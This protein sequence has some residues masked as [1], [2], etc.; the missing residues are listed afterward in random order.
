[1]SGINE[2]LYQSLLGDSEYQRGGEARFTNL[3]S[4]VYDPSGSPD[5]LSP[6][7]HL[8]LGFINRS[9]FQKIEGE[10][11]L[12]QHG[13]L[14][15]AQWEGRKAWAAGYLDLPIVK[16]WWEVEKTQAVY[17]PEFVAALVSVTR[18]KVT[19]PGELGLA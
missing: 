18:K 13:F 12:F 17:R 19:K 11:Y 10:Y 9:M 14:D 3:V 5:E 2:N 6:T 1:M 7:D 16:A 4:K 15:P 8:V